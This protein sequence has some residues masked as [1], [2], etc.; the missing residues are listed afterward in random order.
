M[1][2]RFASVVVVSALAL[3]ASAQ[4]TWHVDALA[5]PPFTG[6]AAQPF[7]SIESA[8]NSPLTQAG[9]RVLVAPG[10]YPGFVCAKRLTIESSGG[11]TVTA[12]EPT[13]AAWTVRF[14]PGGDAATLRGFTLW[15]PAGGDAVKGYDTKV[16]RC[17]LLGL[18]VAQDSVDACGG[19]WMTN[20]WVSGFERGINGDGHCGVGVKNSILW[21][22]DFDVVYD[23]EYSCFGTV[24]PFVFTWASVHADPLVHDFKGHDFHLRPGSPC[25]D[26]GDPTSPLDPDG[27]RADMGPLP[28]DPNYD[29]YVGYCTAQ[30]TS[31]GCTPSISAIGTPSVT[32]PRPFWLRCANQAPQT[33]GLL[34]YGYAPASVAYQGGFLCVAPPTRRTA[35]LNSGGGTAACSGVLAYD[36]TPRIHSGVDPLLSLGRDVHFQFWS[37][38]PLANSGAN[39]SDALRVRIAP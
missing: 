20:C 3:H 31:Q 22:N 4:S 21:A 39:R 14:V 27:T 25:I 37:R 7:A 17:I 8:I 26:A 24:S 32:S 10:V 6:S 12:I 29:P 15:G 23:V 33:S 1:F 13:Q 36:F 9:D 19:G 2:A 28:F 11:P 16:E 34:F 38:D 30:V 18:G 35:L 5:T